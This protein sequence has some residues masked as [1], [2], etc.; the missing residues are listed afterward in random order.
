MYITHL[1]LS[2]FR[3]YAK[4]ELDL[5]RGV[6]LILGDNA[7]GKS[8]L[9]EAVF[10][11]ATTR[12]DRSATDGELIGWDVLEEPQPVARVAA[13]VERKDGPLALEVVVA[14]R[15]KGKDPERVPASKRLR[16]NGVPRR[17]VDV[18]GQLTAVLFATEDMD[19]IS[20]AP[21]GRRRFL[22]VT[23]TQLDVQYA[24]ALSQ[25]TKVIAQRNALLRRI[26]EGAA[27]PDELA[28][29]DEQL[30]E[31]GALLI[32]RRAGCVAALAEHAAQAHRDLSG[33]VEELGITY[34]PRLE[35]WDG[36]MVIKK[37]KAG[38]ATSARA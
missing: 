27:D 14:G 16:V 33:G 18:V 29:W 7:Q 30:A 10:L 22:D 34:L 35:G 32:T 21:A 8:N 26:Q 5:P 9:L 23:L 25:Y 15:P 31:Q 38:G 13:Q 24:R 37:A 11:L 28:F 36:A 17:A 3:N 6:S 19:L 4:Q 2:H 12:S 20:G 1:S